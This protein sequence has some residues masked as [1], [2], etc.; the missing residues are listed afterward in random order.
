MAIGPRRKN[1]AGRIFSCC[2]R[3]DRII[4]TYDRLCSSIVEYFIVVVISRF[5]GFQKYGEVDEASF[6]VFQSLSGTA[7]VQQNIN[8]AD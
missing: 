5:N 8:L 3:F 2:K 6:L 7:L 1:T 4:N